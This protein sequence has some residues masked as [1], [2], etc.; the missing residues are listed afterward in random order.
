MGGMGSS[1]LQTTNATIVS[2]F[3][4]ALLH[5]AL[6]VVVI[7]AVLAIAWNLLRSMPITSG[8]EW[9]RSG[10]VRTSHERT[11]G[12]SPP[13]DRIRVHLAVRRI[14]PGSGLDAA[15][16]ALRCAPAV[17]CFISAMG[18]QLGRC[19]R[20]DLEQPSGARSGFGGL[21]SSWHR[22]LAP[23]RAAWE[24]AAIGGPR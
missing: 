5:Q 7:L 8:N 2:A 24:L 18:P 1:S 4:S 9:L 12:P 21:D 3:Q 23:R 22:C 19:G 6:V 16:A 10:G 17:R 11:G 20:D 13:A 14:P 15:G